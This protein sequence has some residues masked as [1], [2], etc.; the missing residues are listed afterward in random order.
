MLGRRDSVV[1]TGR[2]LY[3]ERHCC[4]VARELSLDDHEYET[5]TMGAKRMFSRIATA[6]AVATGLTLGLGGATAFAA[7]P[8]PYE[9]KDNFFTNQ[10]ACKI[11]AIAW[12]ASERAA[13]HQVTLTCIRGKTG[14][15]RPH[16]YYMVVYA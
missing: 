5:V 16:Y 6:I 3:A 10:D 2:I 4:G 14:E 7:D 15:I 9:H 11:A 13:G 12:T 1:Q 8:I